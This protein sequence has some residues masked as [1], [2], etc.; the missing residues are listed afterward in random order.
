VAQGED[1]EF[2]PQYYKK[3]KKT[4]VLSWVW[5]FTPV[6]HSTQEVEAE[7]PQVWGQPGCLERKGDCLKKKKKNEVCI[8]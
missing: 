1:P 3:K 6:I 7:W 8:Q 5:W 2:K 4:Y